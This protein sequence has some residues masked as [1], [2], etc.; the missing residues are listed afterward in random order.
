MS[1]S[2]LRAQVEA[3][4]AQRELVDFGDRKPPELPF[5]FAQL[6]ISHRRR[7]SLARVA[8]VLAE[9]DGRGRP[10]FAH[11]SQASE[12]VIGPMDELRQL[13]A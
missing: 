3:L 9:I 13:F 10:N 7:R 1:F 12:L 5:E 2:A 6:Q 8:A 11:F 4:R